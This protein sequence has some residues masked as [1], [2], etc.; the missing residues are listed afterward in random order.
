MNTLKTVGLMA[1]L[2]ALMMAVGYLLGGRS[3]LIIAFIFSMGTNF[4]SYWFSDKIILKMYKAKQADENSEPELFRTVQ[5]LSQKA[6]LPMPKVYVIDEAVPNAFATGRNPKNAAVAVTTGIMQTLNREELGSVIGHELAHVKNRDILIGTIAAAVAGV[7]TFAANMAQWSMFFMGR[8]DDD[9]DGG[10]I[11]GTL[12]LIIV[13]PIAA[14]LL[15]MAI[16]RSREYLADRDGARMSGQPLS[17]A[18]ALS[19][20]ENVNSKYHLHNAGPSTS[21]LFTVN[22]LRGGMLATLFST[23]PPMQERIKR[24]QE[25]AMDVR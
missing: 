25:M 14:L 15:Q 4:F 10:G 23:H 2:M 22:P 8:S 19:K 20:L 5:N 21:H 1:A 7:I 24:L 16:S 17:L 6:G 9:E 12:V 18:S 3:G 11:I 13:A